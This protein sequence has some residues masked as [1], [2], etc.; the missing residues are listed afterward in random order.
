MLISRWVTAT[1]DYALLDSL[2]R[3]D[4]WQRFIILRLFP[5]NQTHFS[6]QYLR[7]IKHIV[8]LSKVFRLGSILLHVFSA[9]VP[10]E[11]GRHGWRLNISAQKIYIFLGCNLVLIGKGN[12]KIYTNTVGS[13]GQGP[14]CT[15]NRPNQGWAHQIDLTATVQHWPNQGLVQHI[16]PTAFGQHINTTRRNTTQ[17]PNSYHPNQGG[18][19]QID[20]P[21]EEYNILTLMLLY[22]TSTQPRTSTTHWP[23]SRIQQFWRLYCL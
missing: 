21:S 6:T 12:K 11:L 22:N 5:S 19:Q 16:D 14:Y 8:F 18:V 4:K 23:N 10:K 1:T 7:R 15:T 3:F 9:R 17:Q 2:K 20:P 13:Q